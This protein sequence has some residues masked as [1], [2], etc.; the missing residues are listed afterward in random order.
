[1]SLN[2]WI[3]RARALKA[4]IA[5]QGEAFLRGAPPEEIERVAGADFVSLPTKEKASIIAVMR[6]MEADSS[7]SAVGLEQSGKVVLA[8][9]DVMQLRKVYEGTPKEA[10]TLLEGA[11]WAKLTGVLQG[12]G[13]CAPTVTQGW[14]AHAYPLQQITI[15]LQGTRHSEREAMI[16]Q[17][18]TVLA[19]LRSGEL[20][21]EEHDDDFGYRFQVMP[22][23]DGPSF[24]E[25]PAGRR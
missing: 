24:F 11:N 2:Y 9:S 17:L 18:E 1:M 19:R 4:A 13:H 5:G 3:D 6:E 20:T 22:A 25:E 23:S 12:D 7:E 10:E 15:Q 14:K 8:G 21:G 16:G